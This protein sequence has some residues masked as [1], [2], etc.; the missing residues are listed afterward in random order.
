MYESLNLSKKNVLYMLRE[1]NAI[2]DVYD[3]QSLVNAHRAWK[4]LIG[5]KELCTECILIAHRILMT[6]HSIEN[7]YKGDWRDIPV[8]IGGEY[9]SQPKIVIHSLMIDYVNDINKLSE[10]YIGMHLR[11][12]SIHPFIDGNGRMGRMILNWHRVRS[13]Q[14]LMIFT[15]ENVNAYY[16]LFN[17][18]RE[19]LN[20]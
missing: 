6:N 10:D 14:P 8:T 9:K 18:N 5:Q 4:F 13:G 19:P 7:R 12:E 16:S 3:R 20:V 15:K 17:S 2:E 11:F 1:S